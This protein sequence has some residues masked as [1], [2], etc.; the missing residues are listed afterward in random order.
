MPTELVDIILGLMRDDWRAL[1]ACYLVEPMVWAPLALAHLS[2][3]QDLTIVVDTNPDNADVND[4]HRIFLP[5]LPISQAVRVLTVRGANTAVADLLPI[6]D[7]LDLGHLSGLTSLRLECFVVDSL[8]TFT[9]II[10]RCHALRELSI[11]CVRFKETAAIAAPK[12]GL[13]RHPMPPHLQKLRISEPQEMRSVS[14]VDPLFF[15][16]L[17][18]GPPSPIHS[19]MLHRGFGS[20]SR[21]GL[22]PPPENWFPRLRGTLTHL[23]ISVR[24]IRVHPEHL[25]RTTSYPRFPNAIIELPRLIDLTIRYQPQDVSSYLNALRRFL[26]PN[27]LLDSARVLQRLRL[28][29]PYSRPTGDFEGIMAEFARVPHTLSKDAYPALSDVR[30][31]ILWNPG[32]QQGSR[33][34]KSSLAGEVNINAFVHSLKSAVRPKS[35]GDAVVGVDAV[36]AEEWESYHCSLSAWNE[37]GTEGQARYRVR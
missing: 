12:P 32:E 9:H 29:L 28:A 33:S 22:S 37:M 25:H 7:A 27:R 10:A 5:G 8:Q 3:S 6:P 34:A 18:T 1:A 13:Q 2:A 17:H 23:S 24:M 35:N 19:L 15:S 21:Y 31:D 4:F 11:A 30:I 36:P 16:L 20:A 26:L 14:F